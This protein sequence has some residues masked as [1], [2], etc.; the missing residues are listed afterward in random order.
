MAAGT[1]F[2]YPQ[3]PNS[4]ISVITAAEA[5]ADGTSAN[6]VNVYTAGANGSRIFKIQMTPISTSG[7][8]S[9]TACT[10]RLYLNNGSTNS[11]ATN[12]S[13]MQEAALASQ[14][15][16][17]T[18]T[19]TINTVT[20]N[21]NLDLKASYRL[22]LGVTGIAANTKWQITAFGNDY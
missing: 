1:T 7:S 5:V 9:T 18:N 17:P 11:T 10:A 12:N 22:Y 19:S 16:S 4:T 20:F 3:T 14:T 21:L 15:V 13:L 2:I 8:V 6:D